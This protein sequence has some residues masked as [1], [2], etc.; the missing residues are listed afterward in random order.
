MGSTAG[1]DEL[2]PSYSDYEGRGFQR[3]GIAVPEQA[4]SEKL[5]LLQYERVEMG[6]DVII[7]K[8]IY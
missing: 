7:M 5:V 8:I 2:P 3:R 1:F 6:W 4:K